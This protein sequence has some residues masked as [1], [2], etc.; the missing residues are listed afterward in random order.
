MSKSRMAWR[1]KKMPAGRKWLAIAPAG[2]RIRQASIGHK[3]RGVRTRPGWFGRNRRNLVA[4]IS[5]KLAAQ[6]SEQKADHG[7]RHG[8]G[9]RDH[10]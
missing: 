4:A 8:D 1:R 5:G 9:E 3:I 7:N 6:C 10:Q 2:P